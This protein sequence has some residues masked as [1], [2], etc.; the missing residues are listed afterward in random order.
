LVFKSTLLK[1]LDNSGA[2]T[3]KCIHLYT[4]N[5]ISGSIVLVS[6][7][8][9]LPNRKVRKSDVFPCLLLSCKK[10]HRRKTSFFLKSALNVAVL[11]KKQEK[12]LLA[13]RIKS[14][15]FLEVRLSGFSRISSLSMN[16]F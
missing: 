11:I 1:I 14:F 9:V 5:T 10:Q 12:T 4:K 7:K 15:C 3:A 2:K 6:L 8:K 16:T 13:S